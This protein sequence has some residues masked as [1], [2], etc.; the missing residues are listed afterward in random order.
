LRRRFRAPRFFAEADFA[1]ADFAVPIRRR[2]NHPKGSSTHDAITVVGIL[3][4][5]KPTLRSTMNHQSI[6][7]A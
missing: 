6:V 4:S 2:L 5:Y 3:D 1:E 7:K